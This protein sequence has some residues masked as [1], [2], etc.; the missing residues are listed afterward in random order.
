MSPILA[1]QASPG[2]MGTL[3]GVQCLGFS[4]LWACA[5]QCAVLEARHQ[6]HISGQRL[7]E[8]VWMRGLMEAH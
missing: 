7:F 4:L 1:S 5:E 8:V 2:G 3:R 6:F